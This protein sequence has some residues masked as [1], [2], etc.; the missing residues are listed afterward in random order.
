MNWLKKLLVPRTQNNPAAPAVSHAEP[1]LRRAKPGDI[2]FILDVIEEGG[3]TH[4]YTDGNLG[5]EQLLALI[6][7]TLVKKVRPTRD[8]RQVLVD[9][10]ADAWILEGSDGTREG[11]AVVKYPEKPATHPLYRKLEL[12]LASVRQTS[13]GH[14]QGRFLL[15]QVLAHYDAKAMMARCEPASTKMIAMLQRRGFKR[16]IVNGQIILDR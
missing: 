11:F 9:I 1:C 4:H 13:H 2:P 7:A 14:G 10:K 5:K 12:W 16:K 3:R 8:G 15:D 6:T